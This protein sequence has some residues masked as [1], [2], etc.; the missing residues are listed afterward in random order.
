MRLI[1]TDDV[2]VRDDVVVDVDDDC[3]DI[4]LNVVICDDDLVDVDHNVVVANHNLVDMDHN[5]VV[6]DHNVVDI[7]L[8]VVVADLNRVDIDHDR[9]DV[10]LDLQVYSSDL[11]YLRR[12]AMK[13]NVLLAVAFLILVGAQAQAQICG[14]VN[15]TLAVPTITVS[16]GC[17][18]GAVVSKAGA[19]LYKL[20][21]G[22]GSIT[23]ILV[24]PLGDANSDFIATVRRADSRTVFVRTYKVARACPPNV[25]IETAC[26]GASHQRLDADFSFEIR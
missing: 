7:D 3:V 1:K 2:V 23:S 26:L 8:D 10:D 5:V 17:A 14:R 24:T 25:P 15:G 22:V 9:V 6:A 13:K 11:Q 4:D 12:S 16:P 18:G 20:S 19:G 21:S